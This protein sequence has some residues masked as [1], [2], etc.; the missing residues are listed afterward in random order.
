MFT[1]LFSLLTLAPNPYGAETVAAYTDAIKLPPETVVTVRYLSF[2][3]VTSTKREEAVKVV[4]FWVNSLSKRAALKPLRQVTTTLYAVDLYHYNIDPKVWENFSK[5]DPYFHVQIKTEDKVIP[6]KG[7]V[8]PGDGKYY[9]PGAFPQKIEG[10]KTAASA[11]WL[12]TKEIATLITLTQS[13]SPV[14]RADW[15]LVQTA[16]QDDRQ[17]VGYYD[18][19]GTKDRDE[20]DKL[21]ALDIKASQKIEREFAGIVKRSGVARLPRQIF[22]FQSLTGGYWQTRDALDNNRE[23]RNALRNLDK[24]YKHQAE[25]IYGTLP[26]GLFAFFLCDQNGVRQDSAPDKI[27]PWREYPGIDGRIHVGLACA[28]CHAEGLRPFKDWAKSSYSGDFTLNSPDFATLKRLESIYLTDLTEWFEED[29]QRYARA[30]KKITGYTPAQAAKAIVAVYAGYQ[31]R[32]LMP[33][34]AAAEFGLTEQE[35]LARL[36]AFF[37][38]NKLADPVLADHIRGDSIRADD[39]EQLI[40]LV[41][42]IVLQVK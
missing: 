42:P 22:R 21:V 11:P 25:E 36:K 30:L 13:Q 5:V 3:W 26:N 38:L 33:K 19:L 9:E 12:P 14:L 7:G 35:Y 20:F 40:P 28:G 6:W 2:W 15:W 39:W 24:D 32:D 29:N 27:G 23:A 41:A 10:E 34:E 18:F 17:G 4:Q 31:E 16:I 37:L 8:W 1:A